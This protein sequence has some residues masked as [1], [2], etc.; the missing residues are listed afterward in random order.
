MVRKVCRAFAT[1]VNGGA[2]PVAKRLDFS[3]NQRRDVTRAPLQAEL[4]G[5][6][7]RG[8]EQILADK[9]LM[10]PDTLSW[11]PNAELYV[12]A[13]QIEKMPR[14][15]DGVSTRTEPYKLWKIIEMRR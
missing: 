5:D 9:R 6:D 10:W 13:S 12:T 11:G 4:A 14:F 2:K 8:V 1:S 7:S 3:G 15:N